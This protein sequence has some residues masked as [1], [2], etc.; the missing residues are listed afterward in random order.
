MKDMDANM[1]NSKF[2]ELTDSAWRRP[3]TPD[4]QAQLLRHLGDHPLARAQWEQDA[5]L[6]RHL[7]RLPPAPISSNFT[8]RVMRAVQRPPPRRSWLGRL[9]FASWLPS[10]WMPRAAVGAAMV[11]LCLLT[12]RQY[13]IIQRQNMARDLARVSRL[14]ALPPV[15][16]LQNFDTIARLDRV[17]V[18]DDDLLYVLQ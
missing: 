8:A 18:A 17:K 1:Q 9:D 2:Q 12:I 10:G 4:E 13:Q 11:C 14:A 6:T 3:L 7:N 15:D 16:W 5:A